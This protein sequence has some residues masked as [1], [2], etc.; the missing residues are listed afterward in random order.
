[1]PSVTSCAKGPL[2]LSNRESQSTDE[3]FEGTE[4]ARSDKNTA[5]LSSKCGSFLPFLEEEIYY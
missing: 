5:H 4:S 2:S 3:T 1:M